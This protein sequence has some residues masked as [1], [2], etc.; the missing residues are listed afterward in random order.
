M[1]ALS[2]CCNKLCLNAAEDMLAA[3]GGGKVVAE[4]HGGGE[5]VEARG[6]G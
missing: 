4:A 6:G 5:E 2:S 3:C 1:L